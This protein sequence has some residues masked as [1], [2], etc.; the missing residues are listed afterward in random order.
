MANAHGLSGPYARIFD[1][2]GGTQREAFTRGRAVRRAKSRP[3]SPMS[4]REQHAH[5][6]FGEGR[7]GARGKDG[8]AGI[9]AS[10]G[11]TAHAHWI[12]AKSY[13]TGGSFGS[14]CTYQASGNFACASAVLQ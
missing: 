6:R 2:D 3:P 13:F 10:C 11:A 12:S 9:M 5:L 14:R 4:M 1:K 8:S 7:A